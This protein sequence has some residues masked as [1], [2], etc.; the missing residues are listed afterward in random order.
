[1]GKSIYPIHEFYS[2]M[3]GRISH[4]LTLHRLSIAPD[5]EAMTSEGRPFYPSLTWCSFKSFITQEKA[6]S[7]PTAAV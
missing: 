6:T 1:M 5:A 4:S 3:G 7:R 2:L